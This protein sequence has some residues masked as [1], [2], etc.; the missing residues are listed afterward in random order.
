MQLAMVFVLLSSQNIYAQ[1]IL[2]NTAHLEGLDITPDNILGF[3]VQSME[4]ANVN[5]RIEGT[6]RFRNSDHVIKYDF[7]YMIV[8]GI[9]TFDPAVVH[10]QWTYSSSALRELFMYHKLLPQGTYQYCVTISP[11][12]PGGDFTP[13]IKVDDCVFKQSKDLFSITLI[14]PENDAKIYEFNPMLTWVATYPFVNE[15]T[16]KIRVAEIKDGQNTENAIVRNNPVY[17]ESNLMANSIV[18]PVY[19]KP[20]RVWQPYAWTVDAYYKGILLGGAQPWKFTIV[21]DSLFN[22]FPVESSFVD[23]NIDEGRNTYYAVGLIKIRYTEN[24]F[25]KNDV[26]ISFIRKGEV[27]GEPIIWPVKRGVN[28]ETIDVSKFRLKHNEAFEISV[29][30]KNSR[31]TPIKKTIKYK[32][33]NPDFVK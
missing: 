5:C 30:P 33:V 11:K 4:T 32:Y 29:E 27:H 22:T 15:L 13:G 7:T 9:N 19:A 31:S 1:N 26:T 25:L 23:I 18:Y 6:I 16:Y 12:I 14:E 8:P 17:S 24:D 21:E 2:V 20:L 28:F 10:P 3:Q